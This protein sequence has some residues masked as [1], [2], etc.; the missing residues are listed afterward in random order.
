MP[1]IRSRVAIQNRHLTESIIPIFWEDSHAVL[2]DDTYHM[3]WLGFVF[4]PKLVDIIKYS[5]AV[6][7]LALFLFVAMRHLR[8]RRGQVANAQKNSDLKL[9]STNTI[10]KANIVNK[11]NR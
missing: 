1:L 6:L 11:Q 3:I 4:V 10:S 8:R 7:A 5:F 9:I 2:H